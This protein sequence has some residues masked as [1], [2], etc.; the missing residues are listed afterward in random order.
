MRSMGLIDGKVDLFKQENGLSENGILAYYDFK[1]KK[2]RVKGTSLTPDVRV[3]LAHELTHALQDQYFDL[4]R[5]DSLPDDAD[6][7]YRSVVEGDAVVVQDAYAQTMSQADQDEYNK[8]ESDGSDQAYSDVPDILVAQDTEPYI[9]GPAFVGAL[10]D[11]GGNTAI[12]AALRNPPASTAALM[13]LFTYLHQELDLRLPVA[14]RRSRCRPGPSGS[15][16]ATTPSAPS[17]GTCYW[18][19]ASTCTTPCARSTAGTATPP[20]GSTRRTLGHGLH[21][22]VAA[23]GTTAAA[24]ASMHTLLDR[25]KAVGPS[26]NTTVD[27]SPG[28]TTSSCTPAIPGKGGEAARHRPVAPAA[29]LEV[30]AA[31]VELAGA[32][33]KQDIPDSVAACASTGHPVRSR[34][35]EPTRPDHQGRGRP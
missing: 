30:V 16:T 35:A 5:E 22:G 15:T 34:P 18:P 13:N 28:A 1:D 27:R 29:A 20:R 23:Q 21:R 12:D 32:F 19:G 7:A 10:K 3:T 25:W 33:A 24:T 14:R 6:Q 8:A 11:R 26:P 4:S 9:I 17:S 2:V 31:R